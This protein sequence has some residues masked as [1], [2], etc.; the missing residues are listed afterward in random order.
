MEITRRIDLARER[1]IYTLIIPDA[2]IQ[3]AL[4]IEGLPDLDYDKVS[5]ILYGLYV[6]TDAIERGNNA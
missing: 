6:F 1:T 5:E 3:F 4:G 2:D